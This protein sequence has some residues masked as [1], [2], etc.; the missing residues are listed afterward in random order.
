[1]SKLLILF[2]TIRKILPEKKRGISCFF[3]EKNSVEVGMFIF[4]YIQNIFK[5]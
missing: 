4:N 3:I 1:M 5:L 2:D